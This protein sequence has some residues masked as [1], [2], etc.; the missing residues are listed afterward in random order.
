MKHFSRREI[1]ER[2]GHIRESVEDLLEA[3]LQSSTFPR[4]L[5]RLLLVKWRKVDEMNEVEVLIEQCHRFDVG[6]RSPLAMGWSFCEA[7][8]VS[9]Y[10]AFR[11]RHTR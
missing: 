10:G 9:Y 8:A 1:K 11:A 4:R 6:E 7:V 2:C 3:I 5:R